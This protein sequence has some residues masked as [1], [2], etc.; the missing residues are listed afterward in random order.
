MMMDRFEQLL[1]ELSVQLSIALHVDKHRACK[2]KINDVLHVQI[3]CD[4]Q[5]E[6]I[7]LAVFV[8]E[9]AA[10]K[11]CEEILKEALKWNDVI[12]RLGTFALCERNRQLT[13]FAYVSFIELTGEK[14]GRVL[15]E[16]IKNAESW[17]SAIISGRPAPS[18]SGTASLPKPY[19]L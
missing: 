8:A 5:K 17:R 4:M 13:Y 18:A 2:L 6:A 1:G 15:A 16:F 10:G 14:L 19:F 11:F 7:L 12:P 3:E 9:V